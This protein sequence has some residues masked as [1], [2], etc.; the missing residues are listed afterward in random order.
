MLPHF[1]SHLSTTFIFD[2]LRGPL[3]LYILS[4][5]IDL[6]VMHKPDA[7]HCGILAREV[8]WDCKEPK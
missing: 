4:Y 3:S 5:V 8:V 6:R 1:R 2:G 7:F